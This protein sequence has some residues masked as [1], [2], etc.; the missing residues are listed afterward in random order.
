MEKISNEEIMQIV[1]ELEKE[2][3]F[4]LT[5]RQVK[6]IAKRL[7]EYVFNSKEEK[8]LALKYSCK[9]KNEINDYISFNVYGNDLKNYYYCKTIDYAINRV[10]S[11]IN[12]QYVDYIDNDSNL[13]NNLLLIDSFLKIEKNKTYTLSLNK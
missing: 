4:G 6:N 1:D 8:L 12:N 5:Q 2:Y 3:Q 9:I 7:E 10:L 13:E 11:V